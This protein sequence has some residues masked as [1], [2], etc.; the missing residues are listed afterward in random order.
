MHVNYIFNLIN[1]L[2]NNLLYY[3]LFFL[4][5]IYKKNSFLYFYINQLIIY[6][7]S[8]IFLINYS[9]LNNKIK[10][11]I[12]SWIIKIFTIFNQTIIKLLFFKASYV[13]NLNY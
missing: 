2:I 10:I 9:C 3:Y 8:Y 6:L 4:V 11:Y 13:C 12:I 5:F 1:I 7:H